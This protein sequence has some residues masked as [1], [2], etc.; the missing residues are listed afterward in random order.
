MAVN[1]I[2]KHLVG[3]GLVRTVDN[4]GTTGELPTHPELL[5]WL[6]VRFVEDGWS[7]KQTIRRIML[8]RTYQQSSRANPAAAKVDPE[9]RLLSRMNRRRLDAEALRDAILAVSGQLDL[10]VGGPT[11]EPGT[12]SELEYQFNTVRRSV[13]VPVF[14]N[15]LLEIFEVFDFAD[16][17]LVIGRRNTSTLPTQALYLMNSPFAMEQ[18]GFAAERLLAAPNL[19]DAGRIDRAYQLALGR[20]PTPRERELALEYLSDMDDEIE[21]STRAEAWAGLC[22][23]L[24]ASIDFRYV[25]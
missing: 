13:Y 24:F 23:A 19:D 2:W 22:Q 17:N 15:N 5:D 20:P 18:A 6:A 4:F 1:R 3:E 11:I 25:D 21:G 14:R 9:N 8:S 16:P 10:T 7:V 12:K